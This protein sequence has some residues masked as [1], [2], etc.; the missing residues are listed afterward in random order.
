[1]KDG[2]SSVMAWACMAVN[3]TGSPVFIDV[4][5]DKSS[6]MSSEV[7]FSAHIKPNPVQMQNDPKHPA[8]AVFVGK[9]E[10]YAMSKSIT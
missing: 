3:G 1:M 9:V 4:T 2:G 6:R 5:A 8:K 7:L 10:C